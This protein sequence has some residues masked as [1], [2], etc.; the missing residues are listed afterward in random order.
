MF[1]FFIRSSSYLCLRSS[2]IW[3]PVYVNL[4]IQLIILGSLNLSNSQRKFF[5]GNG[6]WCSS[7]SKK[8]WNCSVDIWVP[9]FSSRRSDIRWP[10]IRSLGLL[11][12]DGRLNRSSLRTSCLWHFFCPTSFPG[13][14]TKTSPTSDF[15]SCI[16]ENTTEGRS[17]LWKCRSLFWCVTLKRAL[18]RPWTICKSLSLP[19]FAVDRLWFDPVFVCSL[20]W[21]WFFCNKLF[22]QHC[23]F[24]QF[25]FDLFWKWSEK[26]AHQSPIDKKEKRRKER[27]SIDRHEPNLFR[28]L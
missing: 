23:S 22:N 18:H 7:C 4:R 11:S 13:L 1:L 14:L 24:I 15:Q 12:C 3:S 9:L 8:N 26:T 27:S 17:S 6:Q 2:R 28:H 20:L 10:W 5:F 21:R 25:P 16:L 19:C